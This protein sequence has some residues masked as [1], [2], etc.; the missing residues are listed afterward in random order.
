MMPKF[1]RSTHSLR[2]LLL[3]ALGL[4]PVPQAAAEP[5]APPPEVSSSQ[6]AVLAHLEKTR[7]LFLDAIAGLSPEQWAWKPAPDRWSVAECAEHITRTEAF[8]RNLTAGVVAEPGTPEEVAAS[9]GRSGAILAMIVDRSQRFQAP[10]PLNPEK[11]G[12]MRTREQIVRD[13]NFER[14]RTY[15]LAASHPDH[16]ALAKMHPAMQQ[17]LDLAGWLY[18]LSGHVERH[19]KQIEEV[20]ATPGFPRS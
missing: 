8:L 11:Q 15:E 9:H 19:T 1:V 17:P 12:E 2:V 14:G 7:G 20:K 5:A 18:F 13:F 4:T 10:E 16:E 6:E 3:L